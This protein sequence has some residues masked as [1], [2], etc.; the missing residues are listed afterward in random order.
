[1]NADD[2]VM[3]IVSNFLVFYKPGSQQ[4]VVELTV[5]IHKNLK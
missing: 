1:M 5:Q 2:D 3:S 4:V